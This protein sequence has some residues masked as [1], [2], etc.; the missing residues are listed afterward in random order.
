VILCKFIS[1]NYDEKS[2]FIEQLDNA[3]ILLFSI[4]VQLLLQLST[5]RLSRAINIEMGMTNMLCDKV[6]VVC[7]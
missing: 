3:L 4:G 7:L 5:A 2:H 6:Y 1:L